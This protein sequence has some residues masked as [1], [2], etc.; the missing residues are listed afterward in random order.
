MNMFYIKALRKKIGQRMM[1]NVKKSAVSAAAVGRKEQQEAN[2][3]C[4]KTSFFFGNLF[5][6][7]MPRERIGKIVW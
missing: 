7:F 1:L 3:G 2:K 5:D 6:K 4:S